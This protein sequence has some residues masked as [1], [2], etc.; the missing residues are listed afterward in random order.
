M[1]E[2][3]DLSRSEEEGGRSRPILEWRSWGMEWT[4]FQDELIQRSIPKEGKIMKH[5]AEDR[6]CSCL[7]L[8]LDDEKCSYSEDLLRELLMI[9]VKSFFLPVFFGFLIEYILP[10][11]KYKT[12][13]EKEYPN[14]RDEEKPETLR[15]EWLDR[16]EVS[17]CI[18]REV[19]AI[20]WTEELR[21]ECLLRSSSELEEP[22]ILQTDTSDS[23]TSWIEWPCLLLIRNDLIVWE[24]WVESGFEYLDHF[25]LSRHGVEKL[26]SPIWESEGKML[27]IEDLRYPLEESLKCL[28]SRS[29][30]MIDADNN[31]F[32]I[33][34]TALVQYFPLIAYLTVHGLRSLGSIGLVVKDYFFKSHVSIFSRS[35]P[36]RPLHQCVSIERTSLG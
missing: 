14:T 25:I 6:S 2:S 19:Q 1:I 10:E 24:F 29:R 13:T 30:G 18:R 16:E 3:C 4:L 15:F 27:P 7:I 33:L 35:I 20:E 23:R 31:G 21:H 11:G 34:E 36:P 12:D 17:D 32:H 8:W 26:S 22:S 5:I 28:F 9:I